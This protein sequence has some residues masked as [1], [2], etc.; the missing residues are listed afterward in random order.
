VEISKAAGDGV[1]VLEAG[2][3]GVWAHTTRAGHDYG[4]YTPDRIFAGT[5]LLQSLSLVA[6]VGGV[7]ALTPGDAVAAVGVADPLPDSPV[8]VA[9]VRLADGKSASV[10]GVVETRLELVQAG[11][12]TAVAE[13]GTP[14]EGSVPAPPELHSADGPAQPGDYV[15]ITIYGAAQVKVD[16]SAAIEPGQRLTAAELPGHVRALRS[17]LLEDMIVSEGAPVIGVALAASQDGLVWV[18]VNPQ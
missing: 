1:L 7:D 4:F 14:A 2:Y 8:H 5:T 3:N 6:Q 16:G 18:L 10:V 11:E 15:A 9:Q 13:D 12:L 17:K